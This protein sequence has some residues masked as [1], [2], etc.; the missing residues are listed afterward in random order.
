MFLH[1]EL[2][3]KKTERDK[4]FISG[5]SILEKNTLRPSRI[6]A[7]TTLF[8]F[9]FS[10]Y[11]N[12]LN[13]VN[14][15]ARYSLRFVDGSLRTCESNVGCTGSS[16]GNSES[17]EG[18]ERKVERRQEAVTA[19]WRGRSVGMRTGGEVVTGGVKIERWRLRESISFMARTG[20]GPMEGEESSFDERES[21]PF[22]IL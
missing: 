3:K 11:V 9:F 2:D 15:E 4:R 16:W 19:E 13:G 1:A 6:D 5:R 10:V 20:S 17:S 21:V 14:A 12:P 18:R 22:I 7:S 8:C